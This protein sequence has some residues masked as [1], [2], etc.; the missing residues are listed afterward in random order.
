MLTS[1]HVKFIFDSACL[2]A[3]F[4]G[5]SRPSDKAGKGGGGGES[6]HPDPEIRGAVSKNCFWSFGPQFGLKIRGPSPTPGSKFG[7]Q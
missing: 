4:S 6:G 7:R 2:S 5:E 1:I 3:S